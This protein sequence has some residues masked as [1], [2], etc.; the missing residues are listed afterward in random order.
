[1]AFMTS[2]IVGMMIQSDKLHDFS[3]G[4]KPPTS[5]AGYLVQAS[6]WL[7][8]S[9]MILRLS[10]FN[11]GEQQFWNWI[12]L[13]YLLGSFWGL[14]PPFCWVINQHVIFMACPIIV[15]LSK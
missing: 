5:F 14:H 9:P 3:E 15:E 1:M 4:L 2:P 7:V 12:L 10:R 11:V 6:L 13:F 8:K